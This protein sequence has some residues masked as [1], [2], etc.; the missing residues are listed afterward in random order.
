MKKICCAALLV[1]G[2]SACEKDDI[3]AGGESVT[4]N[5]VISLYDRLDSERL[6]IAPKIAIIANGFKDTIVYKN[7]SK[8]ELPLQINTNETIWNVYLYEPTITNNDTII[9]QDQLRFTYTPEALYVSKACGYKTIFHEF[10]STKT[11]NT[12]GNSWIQSIYKL[13]NEISTNE[14]AHIQLYF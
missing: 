11:A 8:I 12:S 14:N 7:R 9:K 3:C 6:K 2:F 1:L 5:V 4:P 10:N 13:T